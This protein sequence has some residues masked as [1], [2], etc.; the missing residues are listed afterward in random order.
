MGFL[1][2]A[3]K[4]TSPTGHQAEGKAM[5]AQGHSEARLQGVSVFSLF[6][7][8]DSWGPLFFILT[9]KYLAFTILPLSKYGIKA[10]VG[11]CCFSS[12]NSYPRGRVTL[13]HSL[14]SS[15]KL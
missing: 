13:G 12:L 2:G 8:Q 9:G 15:L 4:V 10:G 11:V 5:G 1:G 3:Y 7:L 6:T 14:R